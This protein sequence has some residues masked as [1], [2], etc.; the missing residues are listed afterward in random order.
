MVFVSGQSISQLTL[1]IHMYFNGQYKV[2]EWSIYWII[3][4]VI[5]LWIKNFLY[6]TIRSECFLSLVKVKQSFDDESD[7]RDQNQS[8]NQSTHERYK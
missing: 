8:I 7:M 2:S 6:Q 3:D 5:S 4:L 1:S